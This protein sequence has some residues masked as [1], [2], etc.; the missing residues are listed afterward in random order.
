MAIIDGSLDITSWRV[1]RLRI[2]ETPSRYGK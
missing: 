1:L 2:K